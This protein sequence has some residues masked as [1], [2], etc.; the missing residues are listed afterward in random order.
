MKIRTLHLV[1]VFLLI[2]LLGLITQQDVA[3][4]TQPD[5]LIEKGDKVARVARFRTRT[6]SQLRKTLSI[7]RRALENDPK[8]TYVLNRLS[9]GYYMLAEA[10]LSPREKREAYQ[11]GYKYGLR[12]LRTNPDFRQ[13]YDEKGS[14]ALKK[15]P[16][17]V[18][19]AKGLLWTATNLGKLAKS[20]GILETL[21]TLPKLVSLY[22]R[23]IQ[24]GE[25]HLKGAAYNGLGCIS[26]EV[27]KRMPI[28]A[29]QAYNHNFNW[30]QTKIY[31]QK[32][33]ELSP[34]SLGNYYSYAK[35]YALNKGKVFLA[36][37]L[38]KKVIQEP[39]EDTYPLMNM[40]AKKRAKSLI[41]KEH[42]TIE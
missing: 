28:T 8:N 29:W 10:Y 9:L 40:I 7:Y 35:N 25:R 15:L 4:A 24:V 26:A 20:M 12:S 6:E 1:Y 19:N 27:L 34:E 16:D 33:I 18:V 5:R 13:L 36:K 42:L 22:R 31:F 21:N 32:A 11:K 23:V 14:A 2:A 30:G 17:S 3:A 38:L 39:L 41:K 37:K